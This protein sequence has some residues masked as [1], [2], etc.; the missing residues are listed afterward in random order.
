MTTPNVTPATTRTPAQGPRRRLQALRCLGWNNHQLAD[1][2]GLHVKTIRNVMRPSTL[3]VSRDTAVRVATIF[4]THWD[5]TPRAYSAEDRRK[6]DRG[7]L[8]A[9]EQ[10]WAPAMA[11]DDI[12]TDVA[13]QGLPDGSVTVI[14]VAEALDLLKAGVAPFEVAQRFGVKP[15]SLARRLRR[16]G[17]H[18]W[19]AACERKGM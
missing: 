3:Y 17:Q 10:G 13:P 9:R 16:H 14:P 5:R 6:R 7:V 11:W 4:N 1:L 19:A 18:R 15:E 12:D 8:Y 2:T